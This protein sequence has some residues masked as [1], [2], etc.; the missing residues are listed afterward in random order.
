MTEMPHMGSQV[1]LR[2]WSSDDSVGTEQTYRSIVCA[3]ERTRATAVLDRCVR[4]GGSDRHVFARRSTADRAMS[5]ADA[6]EKMPSPLR[7][8]DIELDAPGSPGRRGLMR[9]HL[10]ILR[11]ARGPARCDRVDRIGEGVAA[12]PRGIVG[13]PQRT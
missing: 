9:G 11:Q 4:G 10:W 3:F 8:P 13:Q 5:R 7:R 1:M 12:L 2:Q 6:M